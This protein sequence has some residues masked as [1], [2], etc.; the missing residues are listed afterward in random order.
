MSK[1]YE[2][3][4]RKTIAEAPG[5]RVRQLT[6]AP[7]QSVPWHHHSAITDTFF[8]MEGT[9]VV[10]TRGPDAGD[11]LLRPGDT[12]AVPPNTA[13]YVHGMDM[14]RCAFMIVQGVGIYD[15]IPED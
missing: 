4:V 10:E 5:L 14:G 13:H 3:E 8:C 1:P 15:Y 11:H 12:L 6:L 2:A 9:V 7:G